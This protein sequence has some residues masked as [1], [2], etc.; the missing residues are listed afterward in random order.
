MRPESRAFLL[1]ADGRDN[2]WAPIARPE[3]RRLGRSAVGQWAPRR[4]PALQHGE[5]GPRSTS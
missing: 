1:G 5:R 3:R 2:P 4:V